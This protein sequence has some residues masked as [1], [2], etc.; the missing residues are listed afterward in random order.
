[1]SEIGKKFIILKNGDKIPTKSCQAI[2]YLPQIRGI[3]VW[4][5]VAPKKYLKK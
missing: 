1:M 4:E 3:Y 5:I 2:G